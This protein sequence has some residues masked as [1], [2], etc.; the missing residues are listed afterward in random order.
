MALYSIVITVY[1]SEQGLE[2]LYQKIKDVFEKEIKEEFELILIDDCSTDSSYEVIKKL[3][4]D[5]KRIKGIQLAV[6]HGQ[7]KAVL[8]G[9][10]FVNGDYIITM[11]DDLQ[12]PPNQ[13]P[14][15]IE[16][17]NNSDNI[18]IVIGEYE[19]KKHGPIR[20]FGTWLMNIANTII[21][22]KPYDLKLTSFRLIKRYVVD[23]V[24][25]ISI[26]QPTVGPVLIQTTNRITNVIV[27][28]DKRSFGHSGYGFRSL[29][30]AFNKNVF[31][32]SDL[33]L[34][35][36]RDIGIMSLVTSI[37][38]IIYVLIRYFSYQ[39]TISGWTTIII[40]LLIFGGLILFSLGI[41]GKYLINIMQETKKMPSYM[42]REQ[43]NNINNE[44]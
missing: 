41:M 23:N 27:K 10:H 37:I 31:T 22:N 38:M 1:N 13:I 15:L 28:H 35:I 34:K 8:C 6:K 26:S 32:N 2:L 20:K 43:I 21:Y 19:S 42:I 24:N 11:D 5:D 25:Q 44:N 3:A 33:P 36:V 29:V 17:M 12:H 16:K 14:T 30:S 7:Q 9:F 40:L 39:I 4:K 18:D